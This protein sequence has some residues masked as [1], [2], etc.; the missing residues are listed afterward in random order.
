MLSE[1]LRNLT[2]TI[3]FSLMLWMIIVV[4]VLVLVTSLGVRQVYRTQLLEK[5]DQALLADVKKV[6]QEIQIHYPDWRRLEQSLDDIAFAHPVQ[7]WFVQIYDKKGARLAAGG[8]HAD[9]ATPIVDEPPTTHDRVPYRVYVA[10]LEEPGLPT[11]LLRLGGN[12]QSLED[13]LALLDQTLLVRSMIILLLA[14]IGGYVLARRA[15]Q[16]IAKIIATAARLQPSRLDERLP[17][18]GT[19]DE[20]DQLSRTIN[21]MLD[22]IASYIDKNRE[23]VAHAAHELRSPLAAIRSSVE[24]AL[25]RQRSADEYATLLGEVM[26]ECQYLSNLVNRLLILAEGDVGRIDGRRSTT[27]LDDIVRESLDMFEAVADLQ[28]VRLEA[29][30]LP[31]ASVPGD[32]DYHRQLVRNLL[33]NAIK[34]TPPGGAVHLGLAVEPAKQ[35][36]ALTVADEGV[37]IPPHDLP[38]VFERFFRGDRSR[39]RHQGRQSSGLGLSICQAI[40]RALGGDIAAASTLGQGSTFTVTLPLTVEAAAA[41]VG[42]GVQ[43]SVSA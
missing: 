39:Q 26:E 4:F 36:V 41:G 34:F 22:R 2:A 28:G 5:F 31:A 19:G 15:T 24:V 16:P 18:R 38:H 13:A 25:N 40:V 30:D 12:R 8:H 21:S 7:A 33:D 43:Q 29:S 11:L 20:L 1:R 35:T 14:P 10:R 23:F 27:R 3:R 17:I 42:Q 9:I 32:E 37:G 6:S